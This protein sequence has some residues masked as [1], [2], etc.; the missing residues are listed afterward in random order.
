[1]AC[2]I[3]RVAAF[4]F[5]GRLLERLYLPSWKVLSWVIETVVTCNRMY[6]RASKR[7]QTVTN[8][9]SWQWLSQQLQD[10]KA[11][12]TPKI[13]KY[14]QKRELWTGSFKTHMISHIFR[15][16]WKSQHSLIFPTQRIG[17]PFLK[18]KDKDGKEETEGL[19]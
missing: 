15:H 6:L 11:L 4:S 5:A 12:K 1:M 18:E 9:D 8:P 16:S 13:W 19:L 2:G 17:Q 7:L 10:G 3:S 14:F